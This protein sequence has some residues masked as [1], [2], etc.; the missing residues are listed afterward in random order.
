MHPVLCSSLA[1]CIPFVR[2]RV[3]ET[4]LVPLDF[5]RFRKGFGFVPKHLL[6]GGGE[7]AIMRMSARERGKKSMRAGRWGAGKEGER[8]GMLGW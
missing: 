3:V 2:I 5:E 8:R 1:I 7:G 4:T 6:C